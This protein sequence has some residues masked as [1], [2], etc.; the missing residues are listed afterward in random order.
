MRTVL[1]LDIGSHSVKA[2]ELQQTLRGVAS[3]Q[4][5][6]ILRG[7]EPLPELIHELV[8]RRGLDTDSVVVA[9]RG[10]RVSVRHLEFPFSEKRR[11]AQAVPFAIEDQLP[12]DL[13]DVVIDWEILTR[14]RSHSEVLA[15][16]A[17]RNHVSEGIEM[18]REAECDP[19]IVECE[20]L[21]LANLTAAFDLPG[22]RILVDIG[23]SKSTFCA[24][25]N[26][27][28]VASRAIRTAGLALTRALAEDRGHEEAEAE[29]IKC[30]GG[31]VDPSLGTPLP[32]VARVLDRLAGEILRLVSSLEPLIGSDVPEVTLLG[33]SAQLEHLDA[34]LAERTGLETAR[35]GLPREEAGIGLVAGGPPIVYAP[36]IALALRGTARA[37]THFNFRQDE[38]SKPIDL[39]RYRRDF[40]TTGILAVAV[41]I[42]IALSFG[43]ETLLESRRA[44][45]IEKEIVALHEQA[46][47][48]KPVPDN[49]LA[50]L[51]TAVQDSKERANFLGVYRGNL[52]AL[53]VLIEISQQ[54]PPDLDVVFDELSID[55]QTVRIRVFAQSFEAAERLG[56]ELAKFGPFANS[57]IGD[58]TTDKK[59]GRKKFDVIISLTEDA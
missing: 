13:E 17:P 20:G 27:R 15:A 35:L 34:L 21:V 43:T 12:F 59:S 2:V 47:P 55:R 23:H 58:I 42:L 32:Q 25:V 22:A 3:S 52:S 31:V 26:G 16:V 29:R 5:Q 37:T 40:G 6:A 50:S 53:D 48:G 30:E 14:E 28:A 11:L 38:F 9:I 36:A 33:G 19:R 41:A 39:S 51:R 44:G 54:V 4:V 24:L 56:D 7:D 18:L 46:M 45:R 10:D 8:R 57:R 1:G 49:A